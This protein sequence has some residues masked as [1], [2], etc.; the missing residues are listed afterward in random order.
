MAA[1]DPG[2]FASVLKVLE[3]PHQQPGAIKKACR[4]VEE[5]ITSNK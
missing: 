4:A 1:W 5:C 3:S 2:S